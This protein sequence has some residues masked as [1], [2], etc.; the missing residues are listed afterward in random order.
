LRWEIARHLSAPPDMRRSDRMRDRTA[1]SRRP[2]PENVGQDEP[3]VVRASRISPVLAAV[4]WFTTLGLGSIAVLRFCFHD[5]THLLTW[6]NAFTRYVYLP[7]YLCLLFACARRRWWLMAANLAIVSCHLYWLA[8][9]YLRDQRFVRSTVSTAQ[10]NSAHRLRIFFANVRME[11]REREALIREIRDAHPDVIVLVE[12]SHS[13]NAA[14]RRSPIVAEYPYG[15]GLEMAQASAV[16]ILSKLPI[17]NDT[18]QWFAGRCVETVEI[19]LGSQTLRLAG[20]HA[21]RPMSYRD[22]DYEG[23]WRDVL[24]LLM[25]QPQPSVVV[26]DFNATQYSFVYQELKTSGL[27]SAHEARGRGDA[28]TWPNGRE[29]VPPIRIDQVFLSRD[30]VCLDI[31]EGAGFGSDHKPLIFDIQVGESGAGEF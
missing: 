7:A 9:D 18:R 30:V 10:D 14:F 1:G 16:S 28:T 20:L 22:N 2:L 24:P 21:P 26:G 27:R 5:G 4:A 3:N 29:W 13:W 15:S 11:N 31:A 8:P 25:G 12:F 23:F 19:E 17:K 6:L